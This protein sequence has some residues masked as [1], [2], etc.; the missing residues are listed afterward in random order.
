MIKSPLRL[1]AQSEL[2]KLLMSVS[3]L[4][5]HT[6]YNINNFGFAYNS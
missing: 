5:G 2:G 3:L 1:E 6:S 4:T